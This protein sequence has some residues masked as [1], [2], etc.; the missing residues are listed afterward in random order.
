M[1]QVI[2]AIGFGFILLPLFVNLPSKWNFIIASCITLLCN[3]FVGLDFATFPALNFL[4]HLFVSPFLFQVGSHFM[5]LINYPILP[6]F[7]IMLAGFACGV[8]FTKEKEERIKLILQISGLLFVLFVVIRTLNVWGDPSSWGV[9]KNW[10][11]TFMSFINV[12]KYPP[13]L[14]YILITLSVAFLLLFLVEKLES[15]FKKILIVYGSVP[16][17]YYLLHFYLIHTI[18]QLIMLGQ[19]FSWSDFQFEPFKFG[20]PIATSGIGLFGVYI[21]WMAAVAVLYPL[22]KMYSS[23][24]KNHP[25]KGWLRY[26]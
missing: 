25:E 5:L 22:C 6:W 21:F 16:M 11:F 24:K 12:S 4:Y 26:L 14:L 13:S 19:G 3:L 20:R 9:Q 7:G 15:N 10:L 8:I 2:A 1:L 18:A 23:Y 17:F